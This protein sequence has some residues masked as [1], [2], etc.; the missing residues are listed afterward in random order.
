MRREPRPPSKRTGAAGGAGG[1]SKQTAA[2]PVV[3]P[4]NSTGTSRRP[5]APAMVLCSACGSEL[6]AD[7][8]FCH[9]C[10]RS[11]SDGDAGAPVLLDDAC[12]IAWWHGYV[13][14]FFFVV[15]EQPLPLDTPLLTSPSVPRLDHRV[16]DPTGKA[17][18]AHRRLVKRLRAEG[19]EPVG[20][21]PAW[22]QQR[23]QLRAPAQ[24][25]DGGGRAA[26]AKSRA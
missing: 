14:G 8:R 5:S 20:Q 9:R 4:V 18:D 16:P 23:F 22:Y 25:K 10:G 26:A 17:A 19:W 3:A 2:R 12:E 13:R 21:G 6:P 7:A 11:Q 15:P 1:A 24:Q